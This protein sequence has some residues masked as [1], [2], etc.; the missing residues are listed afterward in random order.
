MAGDVNGSVKMSTDVP[1]INIGGADLLLTTNQHGQL[2]QLN[3][4]ANRVSIIQQFNTF[5]GARME[6][7]VVAP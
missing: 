5:A 1:V 7:S 2:G 3:S 6:V 4:G